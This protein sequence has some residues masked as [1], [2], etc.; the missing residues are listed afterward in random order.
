MFRLLV[1]MKMVCHIV[2][3]CFVIMK[4]IGRFVCLDY[5]LLSQI[6]C[7][8]NLLN[9][10]GAFY[11][12]FYLWSNWCIPNMSSKSVDE[13]VCLYVCARAPEPVP[14]HVSSSSTYHFRFLSPG[15]D[16]KIWIERIVRYLKNLLIYLFIQISWV[17]SDKFKEWRLL[18]CYAVWFL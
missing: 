4:T 11:M 3:L 14:Y 2:C 1:S 17:N 15:V 8:W 13:Y 6:T 7:W 18:G 12:Q 9:H 16:V 10:G 5:S